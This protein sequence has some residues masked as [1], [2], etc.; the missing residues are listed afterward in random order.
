MNKLQLIYNEGIKN[1]EPKPNGYKYY[2]ESG[3]DYEQTLAE[4][5]Y[6]YKRYK[7]YPHLLK[8]STREGDIDL[9]VNAFGSCFN[10]PIFLAPSG[11]H[12]MAHPEGEEATARGKPFSK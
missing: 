4:N 3:A 8:R 9:S 12:K 11:S 7:I 6:A 2:V 1:L 10:I 5:E